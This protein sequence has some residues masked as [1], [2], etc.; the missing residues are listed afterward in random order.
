MKESGGGK[1]DAMRHLMYQADLTRK[2]N[3]TIA[4]LVSMAYESRLGSPGQ[5]EAERE[6]DRFNDALG[7]EIGQRA[8]DEQDVVRLAR[9][10][11]EKNKAKI[12]PKEER[13]GYAKG[14]A[15]KRKKR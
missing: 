3:P 12:L 10:Y 7:R 13:T 8:K 9:E 6:M 1:A 5:T 4:D 2:T 11:V 14:G 15:V